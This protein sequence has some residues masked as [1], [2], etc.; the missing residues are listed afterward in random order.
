[1]SQIRHCQVIATSPTGPFLKLSSVTP[2]VLPDL[3]LSLSLCSQAE[4][5]WA[6]PP[7]PTGAVT[8]GS[9]ERQ[10][11][12]PVV[13]NQSTR[14]GLSGRVEYSSEAEAAVRNRPDADAQSQVK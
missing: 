6:R 14:G 12:C 10:F 11:V 8:A 7:P 9:K 4:W 2:T 13:K 3:S 1:M 5:S